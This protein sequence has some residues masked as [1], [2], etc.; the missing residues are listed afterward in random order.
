MPTRAHRTFAILT[1]ALLL[2]SLPIPVSAARPAPSGPTTIEWSGFTWHVKE[3]NRK[4]GPGPNF[5]S[6]S[7]VSVDVANDD[8]RMSIRRSGKK[9]TVAEVIADASLGYGTYTWTIR[10]APDV[11]PNVVIGMFTWN[12]DPAYAH[13]EIDI[14]FARWGNA[15]DPTN[16]QYVVQPWDAPN[17]DHR[18]AQPAGLTNTVHSFTWAPG[19][20][21]FISRRADG[22]ILASYTYT[23]SDVPIPG[24]EQP[25]IN[26]WLFRGAAPTD[27][28]PV[29]IVFDAFSYVAP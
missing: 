12:D 28:R 6:A 8:L 15:A 19:Q 27:G 16:A 23:G 25:R 29:E 26:L 22:T 7:N 14:E 10:S 9:W 5:F 17:H 11:D 18:W 20:V 1:A 24:G 4:I 21:D 13:R 2:T 3:H